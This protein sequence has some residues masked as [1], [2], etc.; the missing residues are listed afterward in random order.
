MGPLVSAEQ[1]QRVMGY[2]DSGAGEGAEVLVG[3]H[4]AAGR[5]LLRRADGAR[6]TR[7]QRMRVRARGDLRAGAVRDV[8]QRRRLDALARHR[9]RHRLW[10][11]RQHL[12][13]RH[14]CRAQAGEE[15]QAPARCA[16]TP[17]AA[18]TRRCRSAA[19][20]SPAGAA[21]TAAKAR[22]CTR[23]SN[24]CPWACDRRAQ[25]GRRNAD[26]RHTSS[27]APARPA[28]CSPPP[29]RGPAAPRAAA[30]GGRQRRSI[31]T[32]RMP[33][34]VPAGHVANLDSPGATTAS[35]SR[36][37]MA[38]QLSLPRGR[39]LGGSSSI[40]G[41]FYMR[42]HSRDFDGWRGGGLRGLGLRGRAAVLSSRSRRAGAAPAPVTAPT[43][44]W[45]S[46]R[47]TRAACCMSR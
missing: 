47:S 27:S 33:L 2:I 26:L 42:G 25:H 40:N 24:R 17:P 34:G 21:R 18:S 32:C 15:D 43:A 12:D 41:M 9:Q 5:G 10:P 22:T 28:A 36:R 45:R 23:R 4:G 14:Q 46:R 38:A 44:R 20:S 29:E 1:R 39:V 8:L 11:L 16:S 19:T 30:R 3:G 7:R 35:P 37:W 6:R 31:P 13:A